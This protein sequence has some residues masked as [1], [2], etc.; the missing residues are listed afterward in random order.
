MNPHKCNTLILHDCKMNFNDLKQLSAL[1][2]LSINLLT[3][4]K[5]LRKETVPL[6]KRAKRLKRC[7]DAMWNRWRNE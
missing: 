1:G 4:L 5:P 7:M 3:E 2:Q 6:W